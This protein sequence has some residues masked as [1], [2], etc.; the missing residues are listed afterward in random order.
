M[1]LLMMMIDDGLHSPDDECSDYNGWIIWMG[2]IHPP[3]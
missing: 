1:N 3:F 2:E